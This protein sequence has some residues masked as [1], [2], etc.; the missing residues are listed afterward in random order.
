MTDSPNHFTLL[1]GYSKEAFQQVLNDV[2]ALRAASGP[3]NRVAQKRLDE[4]EK[5]HENAIAHYLNS[6]TSQQAP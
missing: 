2:E 4:A 6:R 5:S 1:L 3:D